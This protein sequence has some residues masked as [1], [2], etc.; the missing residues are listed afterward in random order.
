MRSTRHGLT[1]AITLSAAG[2]AVAQS[3]PH[4]VESAP[5]WAVFAA[6]MMGPALTY[7]AG[8]FS[9]AVLGACAAALHAASQGHGLRG[10]AG[11]MA[12]SLDS[13]LNASPPRALPPA[14]ERK[15]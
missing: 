1:A 6:T 11:A 13:Y 9:R 10:M 3:I 2:P 8:L 12:A 15:S 7:A 4:A 5:W 14:E